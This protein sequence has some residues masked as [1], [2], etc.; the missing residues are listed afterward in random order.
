[1]FAPGPRSCREHWGR[2]VWR[3]ACCS[4][5]RPWKSHF[6]EAFC[7]C[8]GFIARSHEKSF[9]IM[10]LSCDVVVSGGS[11]VKEARRLTLPAGTRT[12]SPRLPV[13]LPIQSENPVAWSTRDGCETRHARGAPSCS[14]GRRDAP[15]SPGVVTLAGRSPAPGAGCETRHARGAQPR[16]GGGR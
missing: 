14:R 8:E 1:M 9:V 12:L 16:T 11:G 7:C 10:R 6:H 4:V 3:G 5:D 2:R 15:G 13:E